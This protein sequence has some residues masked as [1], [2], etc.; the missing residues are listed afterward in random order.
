[1]WISI[2]ITSGILIIFGFILIFKTESYLNFTGNLEKASGKLI[3]IEQYKTFY[4]KRT[5]FFG[6]VLLLLALVSPVFIF[7]TIQNSD[8]RINRIIEEQIY[9][10]Y[11]NTNINPL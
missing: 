9:Q 11:N 5:K 8:N 1:M 4:R 2:F 6:I 10:Q 3:D 7:F